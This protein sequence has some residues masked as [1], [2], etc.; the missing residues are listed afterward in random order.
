MMRLHIHF[1]DSFVQRMKGNGK[2]HE[3]DGSK[4]YKKYILYDNNFVN[5]LYFL[6]FFQPLSGALDPL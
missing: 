6:L 3:Y 1:R 2:V 4:K 5:K